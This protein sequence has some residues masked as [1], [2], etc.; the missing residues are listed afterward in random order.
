MLRPLKATRGWWQGDS[1]LLRELDDPPLALIGTERSHFDEVFEDEGGLRAQA[2][3]VQLVT[4]DLMDS[5]IY[6]HLRVGMIGQ[7][8]SQEDDSGEKEY[9]K[10]EACGSGVR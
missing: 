7:A 2:S 6:R 5:R 4:S 9:E 8:T 3:F 10:I 1:P